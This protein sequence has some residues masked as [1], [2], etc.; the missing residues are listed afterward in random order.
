MSSVPVHDGAS[1]DVRVLLHDYLRVMYRRRW[2][3]AAVCSAVVLGTAVY[4]YRAEP[5]YQAQVSIL[6]ELEQP[7]VVDIPEVFSERPDYQTQYELLQSR[8]LMQRTVAALELW[9]RP[10]FPVTTEAGAV[11]AVRGALQV[12]PV[13]GTRLVQVRLRWPDPDLAMEIVNEHAR[14]YVEQSLDVRFEASKQAGDWLEEQLAQERKRVEASESALQAYRERYDAVSLTEGQNIVVQKLGDLNA[15]VTRAKTQRIEAEAQYRELEAIKHDRDALDSFPAILSNPFI[16]QLKANL[17]AEQR[18]YAQL[19]Q[20]LGERHPQLV[21]VRTTLETTAKR[22]DAEV[23]RVVDSLRQ[24]YQSALAEETSLTRALDEAK[25]EALALNRRGIEYAALEREAESLRLVYQTLLQRAKETSVSRE[26]RA[27]NIRIIDPARRP[28]GPVFPRT[29]MNMLVAVVAGLLL[30]VGA[31]FAV[32]LIDDRIK[33]PDDVRSQLGLPFFGLVPEVRSDERGPSLLQDVPAAFVEAFRTV[34]TSVLS[35]PGANGP[36]ALVVASASPGEGKTMVASNLAMTLAQAHQRVL[37][38]DADMRRPRAHEIVGHQLEP[39]LANVLAGTAS[40][41][42]VLR[43]S[44][45]PG[46]TVLSAGTRSAEAPELL[47]SAAFDH[48]FGILKEHYPWVIVDCPPALTVTDAS[49][50]A[51][52]ATG[53]VFVVGSGM[54]SARAARLAVDELQRTGARVLGAVLNRAD[55][56]HHPYYFAPYLR[57]EYLKALERTAGN[58]Q[59]AASS[60]AFGGGA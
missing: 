42:D 5:L 46:L 16:Q 53:I 1:W 9:T 19:S 47:G 7:N 26:L 30:A 49:V 18:Q 21:E 22:L 36:V 6:I 15:A 59:A 25:R 13:R 28:G 32:E 51:S 4:T 27:T 38:V 24:T 10:D 44:A 57:G 45:M 60:A 17:V 35:S 40:L 8:A 37:L 20:T 56:E 33:T 52:R 39:G 54:T 58:R 2:L 55:L 43:P 29:T 12:V 48:L 41:A 3:A 31:V 34:R 50:V 23:N 11:D 14:Q